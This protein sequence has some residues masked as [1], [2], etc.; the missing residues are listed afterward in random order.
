MGAKHKSL[1]VPV[2]REL[3]RGRRFA[4][5]W[6]GAARARSATSARSGWKT[7]SAIHLEGTGDTRMRSDNDMRAWLQT[8]MG[9]VAV[10]L[11]VQFLTGVLLAFYYVPSVDHAYTTV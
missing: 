8:T 4:Y 6:P 5:Q 11:L 1:L 2:S 7:A 10:L 3:F 9:I